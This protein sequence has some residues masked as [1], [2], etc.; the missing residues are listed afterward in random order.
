LGIHK[1]DTVVDVGDLT[2]KK[3]TRGETLALFML[4]RNNEKHASWFSEESVE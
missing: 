1:V 3:K 4:L 2:R